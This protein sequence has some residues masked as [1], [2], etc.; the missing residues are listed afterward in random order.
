MRCRSIGWVCMLC[1]RWGW[2]RMGFLLA[3][4]LCAGVTGQ[5]RFLPMPCAFDVLHST[6]F[7]Q[8]LGCISTR[9]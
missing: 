7:K 1:D 4:F 5:E 3:L 6:F 2:V 8:S 9:H